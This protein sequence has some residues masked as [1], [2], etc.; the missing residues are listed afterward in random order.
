MSQQCT[1]TGWQA[2]RCGA[3][4][5]YLSSG[6]GLHRGVIAHSACAQQLLQ[7]RLTQA[8]PHRRFL[9]LHVD[10]SP[11]PRLQRGLLYR[12]ST[13]SWFYPGPERIRGYKGRCDN[14]TRTLQW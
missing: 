1:S 2:A 6:R 10:Y 11:P 9:V 5:C 14:G 12:S 13:N 4:W 7:E 3:A 8:R